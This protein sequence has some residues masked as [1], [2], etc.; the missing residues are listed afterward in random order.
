VKEV[1]SNGFKL[2]WR[3]DHIPNSQY[4]AMFESR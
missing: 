2:L 4:I 3:R 1:E